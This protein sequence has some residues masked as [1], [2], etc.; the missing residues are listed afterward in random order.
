MALVDHESA[1]AF[2]MSF[3]SH[4]NPG[5]RSAHESH[6]LTISCKEVPMLDSYRAW[7]LAVALVFGLG[8]HGCTS[9][10]ETSRTT[11]VHDIE[12]EEKLSVDNILV[13]PGDEVRWI[14]Y[15]KSAG[16]PPYGS[17]FPDWTPT[18]CPASVDSRTGGGRSETWPGWRRMKPLPCASIKP[19]L[20]ISSSVQKHRWVAESRFC[21]ASSG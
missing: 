10:P 18:I 8:W 19:G 6:T 15:R 21:W 3:N 9:L 13:Q 4:R 7:S 14:N 1:G 12:V 11:A 2:S 16:S 20:S 5:R 17:K